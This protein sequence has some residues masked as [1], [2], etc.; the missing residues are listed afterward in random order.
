MF[1]SLNKSKEYNKLCRRC[2]NSM[3]GFKRNLQKKKTSKS[4]NLKPLYSFMSDVDDEVVKP[5]KRIS[6]Q[7]ILDKLELIEKKS[8]ELLTK[9]KPVNKPMD[10]DSDVYKNKRNVYVNELNNKDIKFPKKE[11]VFYKKHILQKKHL[12]N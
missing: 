7:K 5:I 2:L 9:P 4:F 12:K 1:K 11:T 3:N 8:N 6:S 10:K